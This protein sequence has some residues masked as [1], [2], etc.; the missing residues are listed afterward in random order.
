MQGSKNV[1][2]LKEKLGGFLKGDKKIKIIMAIGVLG[3]ALI[4]LS[5]LFAPS[6]KTDVPAQSASTTLSDSDERL[7]QKVYE[8]VTSIDGV[9]QAKVMVTLETSVEYIYAKQEKADTDITRDISDGES[10][11][12]SQKEKTEETYIFVD[13]SSGGKQA[14]L[15]TEKAP[16]V[17][18]VV[19][20]CEGGDDK[21]VQSRIIDA[22]TTA[23]DIGANRVCV[24]RMA[25][26]QS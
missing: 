19:V 6:Q 10:T 24:T 15:T 1:I 12:T 3:I 5:E 8:L 13:G 26:E 22:V 16:R 11:K 2:N 21:L 7:E 25:Y 4:L 14:L 20:V 17:K 18:G 23:F 9:G